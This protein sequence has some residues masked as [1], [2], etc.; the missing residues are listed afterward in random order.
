MNQK[1]GN[2][3]V[4]TG[5]NTVGKTAV[6]SELARRLNGEVINMDRTF[7]FKHFPI[8]SGLS[9][10]LKEKNVPRHLY[11]ILEP[12][13]EILNPTE[14]ASLATKIA[15]DVITKGNLPIVEG[16]SPKY[17]AGILELNKS[18]NNFY[19]PIIG[20]RY[21]TDFNLKEKI[22]ERLE[23]M[24]KEGLVNEVKKGLEMGYKNCKIMREAKAIV[25][26]VKYL[27]DE[28]SLENAKEKIVIDALELSKYQLDK[29]SQYQEIL[30]IENSSRDQTVKKIIELI[31][32]RIHYL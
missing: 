31:P 7:I 30:W 8:A 27:N 9:D 12:D 3:L 11:Q 25:P 6:A 4:I 19:S 22:K 5:P 26:I 2:T 15:K 1:F 23:R 16:G 21:P 20:I 18:L 13:E 32:P 10:I 17:F 28:I 24:F 14:Y 29:L